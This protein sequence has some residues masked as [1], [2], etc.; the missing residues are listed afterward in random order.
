MF[1]RKERITRKFTRKY[2]SGETSTYH[3]ATNMAHLKCDNCGINF[4]RQ[5]GS[6]IDS[7]RCN[8]NVSHYCSECPAL[9]LAS[10]KGRHT[11]KQKSLERIGERSTTSNGYV[12]VWVGDTYTLS[13]HTYCGSIFEHTMVMEQYLNRSLDNGEVVH[14]IDGDKTN[15]DI[16]N[17][18][19]MTVKEHNKCHGSGANEL[20]FDLYKNGIITYNHETKRYEKPKTK[21]A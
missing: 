1:I 2:A 17:L 11:K 16:M 15:N 10:E 19:V 13:D 8:N 18:D 20:L 12:R 3:R 21:V 7:R 14:H 9:V 5:M 6:E 4:T